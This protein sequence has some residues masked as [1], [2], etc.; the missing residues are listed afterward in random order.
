MSTNNLKASSLYVALHEPRIPQ[1]TGNIA[2]TC[3]ALK[4]P[5]L[6]IKPLGFSLEDRYLKRAG[7]DYWPYVDITIFECLEAFY[8]IIPTAT[9]LI[10]TSKKGGTRLSSFSF[11]HGDILLFG[12]E[13]TGLPENIKNSCTA[14]IT[15]PM[16]GGQGEANNNGVRSLNLAVATGITC[17]QAGS[18]LSLW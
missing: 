6:L 5:L 10:G 16:P 8:S 14:I 17:H 15:I 9:R 18:N 2:R 11:E 7:L 12:R 1:N 3:A 4:I 13:D